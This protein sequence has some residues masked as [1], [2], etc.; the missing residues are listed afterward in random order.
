[1]DGM[2]GI[3][4][5]TFDPPHLGHSILAVE[6]VEAFSLKLL[7]WILTASPPHKPDG[8]RAST[9]DRIDMVQAAVRMDERFELSRADIDRPPPHYAV[10]TVTWLKERYPGESFLYLIGGDSL[11]KLS[12]WYQPHAFLDQIDVLC[13]MPRPGSTLNLDVLEEQLP[14]ILGKLHI[15]DAPLVDISASEIRSRVRNGRAYQHLLLPEVADLIARRGL[16]H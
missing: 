14:G 5:G 2:I 1:M 9:E 16:F 15:L 6:A 13:A 4:G 8:T 10:G 11:E 3:F 12:T 7:L